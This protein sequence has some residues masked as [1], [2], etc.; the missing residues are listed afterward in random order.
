M[1]YILNDELLAK[2]VHSDPCKIEKNITRPWYLV[3]SGQMLRYK[4]NKAQLL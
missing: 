1:H 2:E 3:K 4:I